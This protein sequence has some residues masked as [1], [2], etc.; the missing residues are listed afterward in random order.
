MR[1]LIKFFFVALASIGSSEGVVSPLKQ[2]KIYLRN[3][4]GE[5]WLNH[6]IAIDV[7]WYDI[8]NLDLRK[9]SKQ[10]FTIPVYLAIRI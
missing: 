6:L 2:I 8:D 3:S 9:V 10:I 4:C 5:E 7:Y 1:N